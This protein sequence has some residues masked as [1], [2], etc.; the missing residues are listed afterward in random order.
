MYPSILLVMN[1]KL[2]HMGTDICKLGH[3][4]KLGLGLEYCIFFLH[5]GGFYGPGGEPVSFTERGLKVVH[6]QVDTGPAST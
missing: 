4:L 3:S 1:F 6:T 5:L 2:K